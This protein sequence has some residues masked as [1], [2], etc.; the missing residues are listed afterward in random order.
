MC[1]HTYKSHH[2]QTICCCCLEI[3]LFILLLL[4]VCS[5]YN[6][7][8]MTWKRSHK[9][10]LC[11]I[12]YIIIHKYTHTNTNTPVY[13]T[14]QAGRPSHIQLRTISHEGLSR[15]QSKRGAKC[16]TG[17]I[18]VRLFRGATM[19]KNINEHYF[20]LFKTWRH[21]FKTWTSLWTSFLCQAKLLFKGA[22]CDFHHCHM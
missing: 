14:T 20:S 19:K 9:K 17:N 8:R 3:F 15:N 5:L 18:W 2:P 12:S 1:V 7:T 10:K 16:L 4:F 13:R 6:H 21:I 11:Y 22:T